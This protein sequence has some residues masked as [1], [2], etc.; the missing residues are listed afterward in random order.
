MLHNLYR[1]YCEGKRA[2]VAHCRCECDID[3]RGPSLRIG[4][5]SD[6]S[7]CLPRSI[8]GQV[9]L[10]SADFLKATGCADVDNPRRYL[11]A[12]LKAELQDIVG[13]DLKIGDLLPV[14]KAVKRNRNYIPEGRAEL[15]FHSCVRIPSLVR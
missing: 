14:V 6:C 7:H 15:L 5:D 8:L 13:S 9:R 11:L 4:R 12:A 1:I 2:A 3:V 10:N